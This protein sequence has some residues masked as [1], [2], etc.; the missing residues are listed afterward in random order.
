MTDT[1]P[2]CGYALKQPAWRK[3]YGWH[4]RQMSAMNS[5]AVVPWQP[6]GDSTPRFTEAERRQPVRAQNLESDFLTPLSQA[7]VTAGFVSLGGLFAAYKFTGFTWD[8]GLAVGLVAG[9]G[10]WL[11]AML[12][13]RKLLWMVEKITNTDLDGDNQVGEPDQPPIE[14]N[15]THADETGRFKQMFRFTLPAGVTE[16]SFCDFASG[17][18]LEQR[19]LSEAAWAG[20]GRPFSKAE[21]GTLLDSL[22]RSGI[23]R[24]K[25]ERHPAQGRELTGAGRRS[26][27]KFVYTARAH[28]HANPAQAILRDG[29]TG[30]AAKV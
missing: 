20:H 12:V 7:V 26:L 4:Q 24:W 28:A 13:N 16:Q 22:T 29:D 17:V 11:G 25:N 9:A 27:L 6:G 2:R 8:Y 15:V 14:L 3:A 5:T 10:Y 1:C 23:I 19:G 21:Y 18:T 30:E